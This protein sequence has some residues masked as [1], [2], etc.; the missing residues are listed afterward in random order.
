MVAPEM[1]APVLLGGLTGWHEPETPPKHLSGVLRTRFCSALSDPVA[2]EVG[3]RLAERGV[4]GNPVVRV[5][6]EAQGKSGQRQ[7]ANSSAMTRKSS[8]GPPCP[9]PCT[10]GVNSSCSRQRRFQLKLAV[11]ARP[12]RVSARRAQ[13]SGFWGLGLRGFI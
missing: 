8:T 4:W 5:Q 10:P 3:S 9:K 1:E 7:Q 2:R 13:V 11:G 12:K 6:P